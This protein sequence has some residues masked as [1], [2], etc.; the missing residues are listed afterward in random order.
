LK[1]LKKHESFEA[2]YRNGHWVFFVTK[3]CCCHHHSANGI[4]S[5]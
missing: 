1:Y 2:I 3:C 4:L 5:Q